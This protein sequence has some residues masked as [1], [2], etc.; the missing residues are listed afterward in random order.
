MRSRCIAFFVNVWLNDCIFSYAYTGTYAAYT[1]D[2]GDIYN[3][4]D[5]ANYDA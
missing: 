4:S 3:D 1:A 2:Y 5:L